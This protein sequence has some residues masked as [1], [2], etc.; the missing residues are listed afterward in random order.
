MMIQNNWRKM[1]GF[2]FSILKYQRQLS[3]NMILFSSRIGVIAVALL[4]VERIWIN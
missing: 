1:A 3:A 2:L 4:S